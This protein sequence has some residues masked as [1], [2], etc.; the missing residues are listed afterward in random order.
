MRLRVDYMPNAKCQMRNAK[1]LKCHFGHQSRRR[2]ADDAQRFM[3]PAGWELTP[4]P[5]TSSL[6]GEDLCYILVCVATFKGLRQALLCAALSGLNIVNTLLTSQ[7]AAELVTH[8][9]LFGFLIDLCDNLYLNFVL[10]SLLTAACK[11]LAID[12][13]R[14]SGEEARVIPPLLWR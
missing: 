4:H 9:S 6:F 8:I 3:R 2:W 1:R 11:H 7:I 13:E 10:G 5:S 14:G 12:F